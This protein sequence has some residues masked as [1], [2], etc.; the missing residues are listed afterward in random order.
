MN[1][2]SENLISE[3]FSKR[4]DATK[5]K[6]GE[7]IAIKERIFDELINYYAD[8]KEFFGYLIN[9]NNRYLEFLR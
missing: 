4:F 6:E 8:M 1:E 7:I 9:F 5:T 2:N 3:A